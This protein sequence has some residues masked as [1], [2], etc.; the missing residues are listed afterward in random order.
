[1]SIFNVLYDLNSCLSDH[2]IDP[3]AVGII[4]KRD[5]FDRLRDAVTRENLAE[6]K[7]NE[8]PAF[9]YAG[10]TFLDGGAWVYARAN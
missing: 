8:G 6:G 7:W 9:H 10:L 2:N 3:G 4:L 5:D 1:M